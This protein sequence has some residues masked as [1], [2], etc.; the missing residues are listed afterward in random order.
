MERSLPV[1]RETLAWLVVGLVILAY[2]AVVLSSLFGALL[3]GLFLYYATRP[4]YQWLNDRIDHP[5]VS[6][7]ATLLLVALPMLLVVGYGAFVGLRELDQFL[8]ATNLEEL[9]S[10]FQPYLDISDS[11]D[12][13]RWLAIVRD[14]AGRIRSLVGAVALWLL[15]IFVLVTVA[16]YLLRDDQKIGRWFRETFADYP[17]VLE[18]ADGVDDDLSTLY[19]GNLLTIIATSAIGVVTFYALNLLAPQGAGISYPILLGLLIGIA[20]LVPAVGMK[21]V[22]FPYAAYLLWQSR[23]GGGP[24]WFPIAFF[25]VTLLVVDSFP[26]IFVRSYISKGQLN[27]GLVMLSYVLGAVA[28]GWYGVFFAPVLLVLSLHFGRVVVPHL[29]DRSSG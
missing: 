1:E 18:Y 19:T 3:V 12:R 13:R 17:L 14:N 6:A 20:T 25:V 16:F 28:F 2:V 22:Y 24:L 11:L 4:A 10:A 26:D 7:T 5:D 23:T 8:S 29:V 27:M 15:R 9:R 21:I